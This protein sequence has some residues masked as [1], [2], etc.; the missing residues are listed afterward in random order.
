LQFFLERGWVLRE[1][2]ELH[3]R[4]RF[5]HHV[6]SEALAMGSLKRSLLISLDSTQPVCISARYKARHHVAEMK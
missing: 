1:P 2:G 6:V 3:K 5:P 4:A